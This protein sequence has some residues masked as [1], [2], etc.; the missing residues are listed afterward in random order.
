VNNSFVIPGVIRL[1]SLGLAAVLLAGCGDSSSTSSH[2]PG[3]FAKAVAAVQPTEFKTIDWTDLMP[4]SDLEALLNPPEYIND[5]QDG[6]AEDQLSSQIRAAV[7]QAHEDPYQQAL[8]S[9]RVVEDMNGQAIRL[10]GFIVPL[11][12]DDDRV[13]T[14]FFLVPFFGACIHVPP[15]PPNQIILVNAPDGLTLEA[16]YDPFWV[17]GVLETTLTENEVATSAY[18]LTMDSFEPYTEEDEPKDE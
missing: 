15:P 7:A 1:C 17:S 6:S 11:E 9:T 5:I 8:V 12:F 14:Q 13:I 2:S 16:L 4:E 10:A 3:L 18:T